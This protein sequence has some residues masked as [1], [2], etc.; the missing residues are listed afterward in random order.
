MLA[1]KQRNWILCAFLLVMKNGTDT[2]G[3]SLVIP[4]RNT[5][6]IELSYNMYLGVSL[7][8][9]Y[10]KVLKVR[11]QIDVCIPVFILV[12]LTKSK[13]QKQPKCPLGWTFIS[14]TID[15]QMNKQNVVYKYKWNISL[16][17]YRNYDT[18]YNIVESYKHY[19]K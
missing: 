10:P 15:R 8:G 18:C 5:I 7:L 17:K 13:R 16:K 14:F 2:I 3:I 4:K 1:R 9:T 11:A 6:N 12:L 19:S